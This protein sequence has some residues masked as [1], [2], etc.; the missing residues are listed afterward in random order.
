M[1]EINKSEKTTKKKVY[2]SPKIEMV[3]IE[4]EYSIAVGSATVFP[5]D[6]SFKVYQSWDGEEL[7]DEKFSW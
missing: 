2:V 7:K 4:H 1:A 6:D 5:T 3:S